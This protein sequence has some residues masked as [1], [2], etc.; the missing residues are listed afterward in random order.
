MTVNGYIDMKNEERYILEFK[1]PEE[2]YFPKN[3][4]I[5]GKK[6]QEVIRKHLFGSFIAGKDYKIDY[7]A[8]FPIYSSC[9]K[10]IE[11]KTGLHSKSGKILCASITLSIPIAL[12]LSFLFKAY[13]FSLS[14]VLMAIII[15]YINH[16]TKMKPKLKAAEF[17]EFGFE[18]LDQGKVKVILKN[19]EY[20]KIVEEINKTK[21]NQIKED[22]NIEK[23]P[24]DSEQLISQSID[25]MH[26]EPRDD[27]ET[28]RGKEDIESDLSQPMDHTSLEEINVLEQSEIREDLNTKKILEDNEQTITEPLDEVHDELR[29]DIEIEK[30]KEDNES[31]LSQPTD[32]TSV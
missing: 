22:L 21:I 3:C 10:R 18:P 14:I 5:C 15:P 6:T 11:M 29:D 32:N 16:R 1:T 2:I 19:T 25:E 9:K 13:F 28:E 17:F 26:D 24:E 12:I 7:T 23:I 27:I 4:L 31:D 20:A 8:D 30:E